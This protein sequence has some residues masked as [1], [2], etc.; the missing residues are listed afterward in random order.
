MTRV[1]HAPAGLA[2]WTDPARVLA[3]LAGL[4]GGPPAAARA[5]YLR[6]KPGRSA[7]AG[8]ELAWP[9]GATTRA[10]LYAAEPGAVAAAAAKAA[11]LARVAPPAGPALAV[12]EDPPALFLAWPADRAV[13]GLAAAADA[14]RLKNRL[15]ATAPDLGLAGARASGSRTTVRLARW[16]PERRA[17]LEARVGRR[18]AAGAPAG[19]CPLW[20]R[21]YPARAFAVQRARWHAAAAIAGA[22]APRVRWEDPERALLGIEDV[23][24]LRWRDDADQNEGLAAALRAVHGAPPD[25]PLP[26]RGDA[27]ALEAARRTLALLAAADAGGPLAAAARGL[28]AG[29]RRAATG[30]GPARVAAIHGDLGPDQVLVTP[31]GIALLDWDEMACGDPHEDPASHAAAA[32]LGRA[33]AEALAQAALGAGYDARRFRWQLALAHARRALEGLQAARPDWRERAAERLDRAAA[34]LASPRGVHRA[35]APPRPRRAHDPLALALRAALAAP[36]AARPAWADGLG[37]AAVWPHAEG[38]LV[39]LAHPSAPGRP[40]RW[41]TLGATP[42]VW[43]F[44]SDPAL[45]AL[46]GLAADPRY[47]VAGHRL[48]RRAALLDRSRAEYVHLRPAGTVARKLERRAA[49][50]RGLAAVGL[51]A[52]APRPAGP[53]LDGW[54]EPALAGAPLD[55]AA[56]DAATWRALGAALGRA[57]ALAAPEV[58]PVRGPAAAL[59]AARPFVDLLER[60]GVAPGAALR[61]RLAALEPAAAGAAPARHA[62]VHGDLHP[63][64]VLAGE[65]L[66]L[67]DWECARAGDPEEDLGNLA[68]HLALDLGAAARPAFAAVLDGHR[69]AGATADRRLVSLHFHLSLVRVLALHA[70]RPAARRRVLALAAAD[71]PEIAPC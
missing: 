30:L 25:V 31:A 4:P 11:T 55:P 37:L 3:A 57:H 49:V 6:W 28:A 61:A 34:T 59:D 17:V 9:D 24:G 43:D 14:R 52:A 33:P 67:V 39:R 12:L 53:G 51:P 44:P 2:A 63:A 5:T 29:L 38:A 8:L 35:P 42:E 47:A 58:L 41:V 36:R 70:W 46:P 20:V 56:A 10:A 65:G 71:L 27:A 21:A 54:R 69:A 32:G 15:N 66:A 16:K 26:A 7:L 60:A 18:D 40:A 45:P 13:R 23:G 22:R 62:L 68:A 48:G 50:H 19:E 1:A 64:Q